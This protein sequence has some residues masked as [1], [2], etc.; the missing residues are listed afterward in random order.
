MLEGVSVA[1]FT[2][3]TPVAL[4]LGLVAELPKIGPML[5]GLLGMRGPVSRNV[6]RGP[7]VAVRSTG[8]ASDVVAPSVGAIPGEMVLP[9]PAPWDAARI[10]VLVERGASWKYLDEGDMRGVAWRSPDFD[11]GAWKSGVA[12]LGYGEDGLGTEVAFGGDPDSKRTTTYFRA[13]FQVE[14]PARYG[15]V[16]ILLRRDDGAA[17]F[18]NGK[19]VVRDNLPP[20][21]G[22]DDAAVEIAGGAVEGHYFPYTIP[23]SALRAGE[24]TIAVEVHQ[25]NPQSSDVVFDLGMEALRKADSPQPTVDREQL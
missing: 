9:A 8:V 22:P 4:R 2:D 19:E 12:P 6:R 13:T 17:I 25:A 3:E 7:T 14:D 16:R 18:L 11:H 5:P 10:H 1:M 23:V 21:A 20:N 15:D 24:N